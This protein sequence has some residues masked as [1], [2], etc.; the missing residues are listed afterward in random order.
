ME[1]EARREVFMGEMARSLMSWPWPMRVCVS[2][3]VMTLRT[4]MLEPVPAVS[5]ALP[6]TQ[7]RGVPASSLLQ[8]Q[9]LRL[10]VEISLKTR[11]NSMGLPAVSTQRHMKIVEPP[12]AANMGGLSG[13]SKG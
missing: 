10:S 7:R 6:A 2:L 1:A 13:V 8:A 12:R 3:P 4:L 11:M 5:G 9:L